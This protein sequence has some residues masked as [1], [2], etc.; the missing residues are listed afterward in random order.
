M[1]STYPQAFAFFGWRTG[2]RV[3]W[4]S[5]ALVAQG[6]EH[7]SPK[8]GVGRSN[9]LGGTKRE[10][11]P[12]CAKRWHTLFFVP[13]V[14]NTAPRPDLAGFRASFADAILREALACPLFLCPVGG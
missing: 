6:I 5:C 8:A 12:Y 1:P 2:F 13:G 14:K 9:R 4:W 7:R 3:N 11:M 10:G